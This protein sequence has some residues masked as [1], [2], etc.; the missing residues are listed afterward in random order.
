MKTT[1]NPNN[2]EGFLDITYS[3]SLSRIGYPIQCTTGAKIP[4]LGDLAVL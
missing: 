1:N 3:L 2:A 4:T